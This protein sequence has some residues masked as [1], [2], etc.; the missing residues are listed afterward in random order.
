M[1]ISPSIKSL[2]VE[3]IIAWKVAGELHIPKNITVGSNSPLCFESSLSLIT[4]LDSNVV[5]PPSDIQFSEVFGSFYF[6]RKFGNKREGISV[7]DGPI[8]QV[9]IVLTW[10]QLPVFLF[11]EEKWGCHRRLRRSDVSFFQVV[12]EEFI[13]FNLFLRS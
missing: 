8:I 4:I 5:V 3:S 6:I 13:Q 7:F 1:T 10:S 2:K 11:D 9:P 12:F